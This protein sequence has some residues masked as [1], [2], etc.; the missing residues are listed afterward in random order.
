VQRW[1]VA[2]LL[3][4]CLLNG[5]AGQGWDFLLL[6]QQWGQSFCATQSQSCQVPSGT[7]WF[8]LHGLWPNNNDT[9]YPSNCGGSTFNMGAVQSIEGQ[10]NKYWTNYLVD[11]T[12]QSF[13]AHEYNKHGTCATSLPALGNELKFF[14]GALN[15]RNLYDATQALASAGITPSNSNMYTSAQ[16]TAAVQSVYGAAPVLGCSYSNDLGEDVLVEIALCIGKDLRI[17]Q[18]DPRV[19]SKGIERSCG[20][21]FYF[22]QSSGNY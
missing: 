11:D 21:G 10:L 2:V 22:L 13:W 14:S 20:G 9:S 16:V 1:Q 17:F 3:V 7:S 5:A 19:Y 18:C 6:V 4:V 15:L 8:T 12:A